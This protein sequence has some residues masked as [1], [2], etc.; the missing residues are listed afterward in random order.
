LRIVLAR[1]AK[2]ITTMTSG[3]SRLPVAPS[4]FNFTQCVESG[5]HM[6]ELVPHMH[7]IADEITMIKSVHTHA[8]NH[9]PACTFLMTG[10]EVPGKPSLASWISYGL[11]SESSDLPV[12]VAFTP[13]FPKESQVQALFT[14]M[15]SS[16]VLPTK[17]DGVALRGS[18]DPVL[19]VRILPV[20]IQVNA[21][22]CSM[23]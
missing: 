9:E 11:G 17:Y 14:R 16:G 20:L 8:I 22:P 7:G 21:A 5:I 6:S 2:R 19:Y 12:F 4:M 23:H 13:A 3:Q 15:W 10:S 18:G 1:K